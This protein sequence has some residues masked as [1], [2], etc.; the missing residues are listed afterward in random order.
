[1]VLPW[2]TAIE[3]NFFLLKLESFFWGLGVC[4]S[5]GAQPA[6]FKLQGAA[7]LRPS[8][9]PA[10]KTSQRPHAH[11]AHEARSARKTSGARTASGAGTLD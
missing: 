5:G 2:V 11:N 4:L 3:S 6:C 7:G 9:R 10:D 1:M 8:A